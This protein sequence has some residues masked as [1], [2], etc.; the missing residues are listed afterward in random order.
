MNG[1]SRPRVAI[2]GAGL[3]GLGCALDCAA[4]GLEVT[5]LEASD[6]VGGR[7]RTDLVDGFRLDRGFQVLLTAYPEARRVLDYRQLDL[8]KF[9]PG[10]LIRCDGGFR[11]LADPLR[12]PVAGLGTVLGGTV[13]LADA[14][15]IA[16]LQ[17]RVGGATATGDRAT[18][19][20]AQRLASEGFSDQVIRRFFRPFFGGV[21][22]DTE[23]ETSELQLEFVFRMFAAGAIAVPA[24]GMGEIATQLADRLPPASVRTGAAAAAVTGG[25]VTLASGEVVEADAVVVATD[26][27]AAA[28]LVG[29]DAAP[30]WRS[31]TCLYFAAETAPIT[32]PILVLDGENGG[33]VNNLCVSSEISPEL[34]PAGQALVSVTVVGRDEASQS[35]VRDQLRSW[36]G[37]AVDGWRHLA[38]YHIE[39]AL[40]AQRAPDFDP[41]PRPPRVGELYLCGDHRADSSINGAL[42]SGRLAARAVI[43]DL[44]AGDP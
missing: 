29:L 2:V 5:V 37:A 32:G 25:S 19:S 11:R 44:G 10:A 15:R 30:S 20:T 23:L 26:G 34:A 16:R 43:E 38:S 40:P 36:F 13:S 12:R 14:L 33:P 39:R 27:S 24:R 41:S 28:E 8:R 31:T 3:A 17:A 4:A 21:F 9:F 6:G 7:V 18:R 1:T 22:L 42:R 35:A